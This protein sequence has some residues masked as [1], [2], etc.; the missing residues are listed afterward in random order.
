ML[1]LVEDPDVGANFAI[2]IIVRLHHWNRLELS[3]TLFRPGIMPESPKVEIEETDTRL[4]LVQ[5]IAKIF[6]G[7]KSA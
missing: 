5:R 6:T 3:A 7:S 1:G 4:S 2:L